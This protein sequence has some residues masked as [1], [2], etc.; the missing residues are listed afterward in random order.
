MPSRKMGFV[1][2]SLNPL[3]QFVKELLGDIFQGQFPRDLAKLSC[4][5]VYM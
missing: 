3:T 4:F 2:D 1:K 5:K